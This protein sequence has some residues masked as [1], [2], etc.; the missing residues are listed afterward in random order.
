MCWKVSLMIDNTFIYYCVTTEK[1]N[2]INS[3]LNVLNT[4][5]LSHQLK[6]KNFHFFLANTNYCL[7]L[8]K[9]TWLKKSLNIYFLLQFRNHELLTVMVSNYLE[10]LSLK[11]NFK[12]SFHKNLDMHWH[13]S[14]AIYT[15][16]H[17]SD[18]IYTHKEY[19]HTPYCIIL[20]YIILYI[21]MFDICSN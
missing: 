4:M 18:A 14:D 20:C 5:Q 3:L 16:W 15:S 7:V 21:S 9:N 11:G 12:S 10:K 19:T 1:I 17:H 8:K 13:H 6:L 2:S